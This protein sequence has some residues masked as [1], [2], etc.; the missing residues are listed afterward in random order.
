MRTSGASLRRREQRGEHGVVRAGDGSPPPSLIAAG[1]RA[2]GLDASPWRRVAVRV[3]RPA[4]SLTVAVSPVTVTRISATPLRS[5]NTAAAPG[6]GGEHARD[7]IAV[8]DSDR[9]GLG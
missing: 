3:R 2:G 9:A 1:R 6:A 4:A 7:T 8:A 5:S